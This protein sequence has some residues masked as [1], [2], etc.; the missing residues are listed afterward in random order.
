MT[1]TFLYVAISF[2]ICGQARSDDQRPDLSRSYPIKVGG[3]MAKSFSKLDIDFAKLKLHGEAITA[4]PILIEPGVTG[5]VLLGNGTYGYAP[6]PGKNFDGHFRA[7]MLRFNPKD[8]GAILK[9][10]AGESI[11]DKGAGELAL[12]I[13]VAK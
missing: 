2:V 5:I 1:S 8:A 6:E 10:S 12:S 11:T 7:A 9:L 13:V 4:V 3:S